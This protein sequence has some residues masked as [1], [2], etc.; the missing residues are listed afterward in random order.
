[1]WFILFFACALAQ[2]KP[3]PSLSNDFVADVATTINGEYQVC[4]WYADYSSDREAYHL[5]DWGN[6][7]E[8]E[9]IIRLFY[10]AVEYDVNLLDN[11]CKSVHNIPLLD[12]PFNWI[13]K[14]EYKS[15]CQDHSSPL[16]G[17]LWVSSENNQ[18]KE[19]CVDGEVPLWI[20]TTIGGHV[21]SVEFLGGYIPG[22][23]DQSNFHVPPICANYDPVLE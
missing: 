10:G 15:P 1:L 2:L 6:G 4:K 20:S 9:D 22:P 11:Q 7:K 23:P 13:A 21:T 17:D 19:C 16:V 8:T 14:A 3:K 12:P 5:F 18:Y